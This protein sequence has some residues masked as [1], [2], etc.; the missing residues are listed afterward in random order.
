MIAEIVNT[1]VAHKLDVWL[2][3]R[4]S[5]LVSALDGPHVE[6]NSH[7]VRFSP[8]QFRDL[9]A[10]NLNNV[11]K[12]VAV[13]DRYDDIAACESTLRKLFGDD[14]SAT[15][16]QDYYLDITHPDANKGTAVVAIANRLRIPLANVAT[17]G[18]AENDIL[19]FRKSGASIAMGQAAPEVH[20]AALYV[21]TSNS[22]DGFFWAVQNVILGSHAGV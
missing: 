12:L 8:E 10:P 19:M 7:A 1:I 2:Y 22:E 4:D 17:I 13:G 16:S 3:T 5:W 11:I 9:G 20:R 21:T 14:V 15:R 6:H 18:D